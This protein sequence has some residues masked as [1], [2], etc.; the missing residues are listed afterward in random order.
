MISLRFISLQRSHFGIHEQITIQTERLE[1]LSR[2]TV[3]VST[4][5]SYSLAYNAA[6]VMDNFIFATP[7]QHSTDG[8]GQK[9]INK[10]DSLSQTMG[11]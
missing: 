11:A 5:V 6:D 4:V 9:I 10:A 8:Y 1:L 2:G 7:D 3:F